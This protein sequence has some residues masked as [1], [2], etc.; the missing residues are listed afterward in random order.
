MKTKLGADT[1]TF[2]NE[3]Y[4]PVQLEWGTSMHLDQLGGE[5]AV[6]T[7]PEGRIAWGEELGFWPHVARLAD[8]LVVQLNSFWLED[9][10][11]HGWAIPF[12]KPAD[13]VERIRAELGFREGWE[14]S[15][16]ETVLVL[17]PEWVSLLR[18]VRDRKVLCLGCEG[19]RSLFPMGFSNGDLKVLAKFVAA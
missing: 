9:G 14:A 10:P 12:G 15:R 3:H 18:L 7:L 19:H 16:P 8:S 1:L 5:V 6:L 4:G 17:G 11:G 13:P 2:L